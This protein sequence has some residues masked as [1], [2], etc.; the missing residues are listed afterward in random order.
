MTSLEAA[1]RLGFSAYSESAP[2]E[3]RAGA[4]SDEINAIIRAVYRQVLGNDYVMGTERLTS[5]ESLLRGGEI[6]VRD[7]VRAVALSELYREKFFHNNAHNR[8]IE[9]NFK[10]LLG[11]AP[12]DQAEVAAHAAT[13]HSHGYDADI[14][15]YIDSAEYTESF[16]DNVV[17]YF[18]GFATIRAQ[19]TVGFNRIFQLYRGYA[20]SDRS[21]TSQRSRLDQEVARNAASPVLI[22]S[23]DSALVGT[24]GGSR[25]QLF[26]VQVQQQGV[27]ARTSNRIRRS[28]ATYFVSYE[29]LNAT[30]QRVH[31]QGGRIVSITPA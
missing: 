9:L 4:S 7:F 11:R 16:G 6:S 19:K 10:H 22:G 1:R 3:W 2:L 25:D 26:R 28:N 18:R 21:A 20:T 12:Y 27:T 13:Y 15:S 24:C 5:A 17:P 31:A 14:N 29:K 30:L 23:T 8:F